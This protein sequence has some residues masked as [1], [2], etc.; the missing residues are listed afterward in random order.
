M[1]NNLQDEQRLRLE[2]RKAKE[3]M[4][5]AKKRLEQENEKRSS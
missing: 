4:S 2:E 5:I 3:N 1:A